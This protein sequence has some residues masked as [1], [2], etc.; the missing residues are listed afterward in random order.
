MFNNY[1]NIV[2]T[3]MYSIPEFQICD[4]AVFNAIQIIP[5]NSK[6]LQAIIIH[7]LRTVWLHTKYW[8]MI[9]SAMIPTVCVNTYYV[10]P[11]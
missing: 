6:Y 3:Y 10:I 4:I 7:Y 11:I 9:G 1:P 2:P 5:I 8:I